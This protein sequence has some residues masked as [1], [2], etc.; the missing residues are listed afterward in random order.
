MVHYFAKA[1]KCIRISKLAFPITLLF[2]VPCWA[3]EDKTMDKETF[4]KKVSEAYRDS[5]LVSKVMYEDNVKNM[6]PLMKENGYMPSKSHME[7]SK[8]IKHNFIKQSGVQKLSLEEKIAS[9]N[10][11]IQINQERIKPDTL[12]F[13]G[14]SS[15]KHSNMTAIYAGPMAN[16][17]EAKKKEYQERLRKRDLKQG[18]PWRLNREFERRVGKSTNASVRK[19]VEFT[20]LQLFIQESI[21]PAPMAI[22]VT[23]TED[24]TLKVIAQANG[25]TVF[26]DG[27]H[28][29]ILDDKMS[30]LR[31]SQ[32]S[33]KR[34]LSKNNV[35]SLFYGTKKL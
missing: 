27:N 17:L 20:S 10:E 24:R 9:I 30:D 33:I 1:T 8:E 31:L 32:E 5:E 26:E 25:Y 35:N 19:S 6:T 18:N 3:M 4:L 29:W 16:A 34:T 23:I 15:K 11:R 28:K 21:K 14:G 7:S 2:S 12:A 13:F 22:P